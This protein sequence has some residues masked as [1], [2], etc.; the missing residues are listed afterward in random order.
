MEGDFGNLAVDVGGNWRYTRNS[1]EL[2]PNE[3]FDVLTVT[4]SDGTEENILVGLDGEGNI[5]GAVTGSPDGVQ[6]FLDNP[7][8]GALLTGIT[9]AADTLEGGTSDDILVYDEVDLGLFGGGG[10]DTLFIQNGTAG[11][12]AGIDL[13][14]TAKTNGVKHEANE[15]DPGAGYT[16]YHGTSEGSD[17][18]LY[19][20]NDI[21]NPFGI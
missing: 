15:S 10:H 9:G 21:E 8:R 12:K 3:P 20:S 13:S 19:I 4:A 18:T 2:D 11:D 17:V 1:T 16:E 6:T 7:D 14:D 5:S